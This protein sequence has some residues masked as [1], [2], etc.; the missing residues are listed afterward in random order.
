MPF[1]VLGGSGIRGKYVIRSR[2]SS[3]H[4][5]HCLF[6]LTVLMVPSINAWSEWRGDK[7][8]SASSEG[9]TPENGDLVWSY[10]TGDQVLSSGV[11]Y[12]GGMVI[13]SDD[14]WLYC[15]DPDSGKMNWKFRTGGSIQTTALIDSGR[16]Y[17]GSFDHYLYCIDLP[18][19][20]E[21]PREIW[22]YDCGVQI[23]SSAHMHDDT[24][25]LC[26]LDG[27]IHCV[28]SDGSG[29]WVTDLSD[30]EIW[31]T[32]LIDDDRGLA[33]VGDVG[34]TMYSVWLENGTV[35]RTVEHT[36]DAE[37]YSSGTLSDGILYYVTGMDRTLYALNVETWTMEW[38]FSIDHDTYSTPVV[39]D[40][41][42]FFGSFEYL[43]CV[44][45]EDD[46][47]SITEDEIIWSSPTEDYQGGSSPLIVDGKVYMGSDDHNLYCFDEGTGE[48]I[49]RFGTHGY[50]YSSP[51]LHNGSIYFGSSD[52][53]VYRI[54]DRPPGLSVNAKPATGEITSDDHAGLVI[55]VTDDKGV[56]IPGVDVSLEVS[57]GYIAFDE[58]GNTR[59][60]HSTDDH[61]SLT[62]YYFPVSVSSRS[63]VTITIQVEKEGLQPG[64][65]ATDI[66]VEPGE[67][68]DGDVPSIDDN[69]KERGL[70]ISFLI[71]LVLVNLLLAMVSVIF[72]IR[73]SNERKEA[74]D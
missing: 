73:N 72:F 3:I 33:Y 24:L 39:K 8:H 59:P 32:P 13:G 46:D 36:D 50:I 37:I 2:I 74:L 40:G 34:K 62:V 70:H 61:G 19:E 71:G 63:T 31:A 23:I 56:P 41:K 68:E 30:R 65:T 57:A 26:D 38:S 64:S 44:P 35:Y 16:A 29:K 10:Q 52:R 48:E 42:V 45:V 14:G 58:E 18:E 66:V 51:V 28:N 7:H 22:K 43:W 15:L 55:N 4:L 1:N 54:G 25:I 49:W 67:M 47:G 11:F 60:V 21:Q 12:E 53:S 17:F 20:D 5:A 69:S 9:E 27:N 6:I